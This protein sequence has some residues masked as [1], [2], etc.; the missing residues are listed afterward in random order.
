MRAVAPAR[1]VFLLRGIPDALY[2]APDEPYND[3]TDLPCPVGVEKVG[4]KVKHGQN[5]AVVQVIGQNTTK[6]HALELGSPVEMHKLVRNRRYLAN[7]WAPRKWYGKDRVAFLV[8]G[9]KQVYL[10][11]PELESVFRANPTKQVEFAVT[12]CKELYKM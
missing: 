5:L 10:A 4:A 7:K 12:L 8:D 3:I 2:F 9:R 1:P 11:S 6:D